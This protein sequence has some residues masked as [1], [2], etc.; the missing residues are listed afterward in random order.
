MQQKFILTF[1]L[2][3]LTLFS[4]GQ[5]NTLFRIIE[6]GKVG[7]I[8][9]EGEVIIQPRFIVGKSFH[10]G[11]AAVRENGLYGY[12]DT[13]GNYVIPPQYD[14]ADG[15]YNGI[16]LAYI[17]NKPI[18]IYKINGEL[19]IS[20][21]KIYTLYRSTSKNFIIV[22]KNGKSGVWNPRTEELIIDTLYDGIADSYDETYIVYNLNGELMDGH[23]WALNFSMIDTSGNVLIPFNTFC[24]LLEFYN[25]IAFAINSDCEVFYSD[26]SGPFDKQG[27]FLFNINLAKNEM[28]SGVFV[29][30]LVPIRLSNKRMSVDEKIVDDDDKNT[31]EGYINLKGELVLNDTLIERVTEFSNRRA[32]IKSRDEGN[33]RM[34]NTKMEKVGNHYFEQA[35]NLDFYNS[36]YSF[37]KVN[38]KWG[39]IDTNGTYVIPPKYH[40]LKADGISDN[41]FFYAN[42]E[43][44][45]VTLYG[46]AKL[47]GT[48]ITE[49]LFNEVSYYSND[50]FSV[51]IDNKYTYINTSGEI[52]WQEKGDTIVL[53]FSI[54][55]QDYSL[56]FSNGKSKEV[57]LS[58][59]SFIK[60]S[61]NFIVNTSKIDTFRYSSIDAP[62]KYLSYSVILANLTKEEV[63]I[64][65]NEGMLY[66]YT[67]ALDKD[68]TWRDISVINSRCGNGIRNIPLKQNNYWEFKVPVYEGSIKTKMRLKLKYVGAKVTYD[69]RVEYKGIT[70]YSNEYDGSINPGQFWNSL[71]LR[72][73]LKAKNIRDPYYRH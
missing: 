64:T 23:Y 46:L 60:D 32:F 66:M 63:G 67:Q 24:N 39:I 18:Y 29:N 20:E 56:F 52:I 65:A 34:I 10:E 73:F 70:I 69:P 47:D 16:S 26:S 55:Y 72:L 41:L 5:D 3:L 11:F 6:D 1:L 51:E 48:L 59:E 71:P 31:H 28:F 9:K 15:F 58:E 57:S 54:D 42:E 17:D 12:I 21:L 27:N 40:D 19:K 33:Y 8:N 13:T 36:P 22:G 38:S 61:L 68:G 53:D 49:P 43:I 37:V 30:G 7:Y 25:G 2:V 62:N 45:G 14:Y 44:D 4:F 35:R 50:V